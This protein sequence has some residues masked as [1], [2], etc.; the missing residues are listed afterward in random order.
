MKELN[1]NELKQVSGGGAV[2]TALYVTA[3]LITILSAARTH[4]KGIKKF[5]RGLVYNRANREN[6]K[7][8]SKPY[9][10]MYG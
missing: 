9:T 7:R 5:A 10:R 6:E 3:S 2:T 4:R 1:A 8:M